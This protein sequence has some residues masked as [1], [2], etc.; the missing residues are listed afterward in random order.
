MYNVE[1]I[2]KDVM[3]EEDENENAGTGGTTNKNHREKNGRHKKNRERKKRHHRKK[4]KNRRFDADKRASSSSSE[5]ESSQETMYFYRFKGKA[6]GHFNK[7]DHIEQ[8]QEMSEF[9][10]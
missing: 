9:L 10:R 3:I 8:M 6:Y 5:N 1:I 2:K 7:S 4:D